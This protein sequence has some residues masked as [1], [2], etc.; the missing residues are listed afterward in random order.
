M[1]N[2]YVGRVAEEAAAAQRK[3]GMTIGAALVGAA[4]A[5]VVPLPERRRG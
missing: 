5:Q 1:A 3:A 4:S 2:R